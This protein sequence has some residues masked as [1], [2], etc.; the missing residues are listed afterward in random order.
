MNGVLSDRHAAMCDK[1]DVEPGRVA[2]NDL[3]WGLSYQGCCGDRVE[4]RC[5]WRSQ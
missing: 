5:S 3:P 1:N 2:R 4:Q